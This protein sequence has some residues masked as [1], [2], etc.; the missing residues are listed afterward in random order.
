MATCAACDS[1]ILFGGS[2]VGERRFCNDTCAQSAALLSLAQRLSEADIAQFT[3]QLH[4]GPCPRCRGPGP[5]DVHRS[6]QIW[7]ALLVT[8]WRSLIQVSCRRCGIKAQARDL[9]MSAVVGWW[10]FPWGLLVTPV[11]IGR[12]LIGMLRSPDPT[13]PSTQLTHHARL[14][15]AHHLAEK[16]GA[17]G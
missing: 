7:S 1:T 5:V 6:H 2:R 9:A 11:Q 15:L 3:R 8:Q 4:R 17:G 10:G 13:R 12:N 16:T 14:I